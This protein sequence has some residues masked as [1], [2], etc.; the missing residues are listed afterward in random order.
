MRFRI[1]HL[2][3]ATACCGA[4]FLLLTLPLVKVKRYG[5]QSG[6]TT[7][8]V[9][10]GYPVAEPFFRGVLWAAVLVVGVLWLND[11]RLRFRRGHLLW[12]A[13][14]CSLLAWLIYLPLATVTAQR[15]NG[16]TSTLSTWQEPAYPLAEPFG[17]GVLWLGV[18]AAGVFWFNRMHRESKKQAP[19]PDDD[20]A[21][22]SSNASP[23]L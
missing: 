5:H 11:T 9:E 6:V 12:F 10:V 22:M 19:S 18:F 7:W 23:R 4:A 16:A 3:W 1:A 17:R 20:T 15:I 13:A 21:T 8:W 2:L 14:C